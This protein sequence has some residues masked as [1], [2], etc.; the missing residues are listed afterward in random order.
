[1]LVLVALEFFEAFSRREMDSSKVGLTRNSDFSFRV[2]LNASLQALTFS[3]LMLVKIHLASEVD[4]DL[5]NSNFR[6]LNFERKS[7]Y[8]LDESVEDSE[9]E[10][11]EL[12]KP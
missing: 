11:F 3:S 2:A 12:S 1:M 8:E 9:L 4:T 5:Q 10:E 7:K 6:V